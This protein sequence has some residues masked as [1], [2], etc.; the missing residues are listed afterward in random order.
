MTDNGRFFPPPNLDSAMH[1]AMRPDRRLRTSYYTTSTSFASHNLEGSF[2]SSNISDIRLLH[3]G[4]IF[5]AR[6]QRLKIITPPLSISWPLSI[7]LATMGT[8]P[9]VT[10]IMIGP[11]KYPILAGALEHAAGST[12]LV[13]ERTCTCGEP[14]SG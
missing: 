12:P 1:P 13:C 5:G 14:L 11:W 3:L 8:R 10:T 7:D 9:T 6:R 2:E 4:G